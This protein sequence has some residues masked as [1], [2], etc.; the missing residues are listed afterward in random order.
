MSV[1]PRRSAGKSDDGAADDAIEAVLRL[2]VCV[3][4]SSSRITIDRS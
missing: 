3:D 1:G 4:R 2:V